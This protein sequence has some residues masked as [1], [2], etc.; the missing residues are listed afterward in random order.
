MEETYEQN[1]SMGAPGRE[2][3][4]A[5]KY[6]GS[7]SKAIEQN[8]DG[9]EL[10]VQMTKD[11]ELVVIHDETIDRVC[12]GS[13]WVKDFTYGKL[14]RFH[15]NKTHPEYE[16]AQIPTLEEVYA[17]IKPTDLTINVEV[18]TGVVFYPEI[19]NGY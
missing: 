8:A 11:G 1:K 13:G 6:P 10:D 18:K 7:V 12:E 19:E 17:L 15:F 14:C 3:L 16:H 2:R 9:I 4:C 5:G